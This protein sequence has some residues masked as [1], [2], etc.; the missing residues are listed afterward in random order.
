[1]FRTSALWTWSQIYLSHLTID[2]FRA[3]LNL[4]L[5]ESDNA[6]VIIGKLWFRVIWCP[7][8]RYSFYPAA[9]LML[10]FEW[11]AF[12]CCRLHG[13]ARELWEGLCWDVA[14]GVW[15]RLH[16]AS[17]SYFCLMGSAGSSGL[18]GK[19]VYIPAWTFCR[20]PYYSG[21]HSEMASSPKGWSCVSRHD[22]CC[23]QN[24]KRPMKGH[25]FP[26]FW[27][28]KSPLGPHRKYCKLV[29]SWSSNINPF[30]RVHSLILLAA[31]SSSAKAVLASLPHFTG[32]KF[33][34]CNSAW[35]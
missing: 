17:L 13:L 4:W 25:A 28:R 21:H 10:L 24:P 9:C 32:K 20:A 15:W 8:T 1:M 29:S 33:K 3:Y 6:Q 23:L 30:L 2:F 31:F 11:R 5:Y 18:S 14:T 35:H 34:Q 26:L 27:W 7:M 19:R 12:I 22:W 16:M